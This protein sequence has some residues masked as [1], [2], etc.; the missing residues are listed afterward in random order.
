M[1]EVFVSK[2]KRRGMPSDDIKRYAVTVWWSDENDGFIAQCEE[3]PG[4]YSRG[5]IRGSAVHRVYDQIEEY[6]KHAKMV[7]CD[8]PPPIRK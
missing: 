8:P 1:L 7:E 2:G 6:I 5:K 3:M 4:L